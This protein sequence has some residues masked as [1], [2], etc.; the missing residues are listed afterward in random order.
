MFLNVRGGSWFVEEP[1]EALSEQFG[2][3]LDDAWGAPLLLLEIGAGFNTPGV[4]RWPM[5]QVAQG[6]PDAH[7][8]RVNPDHPQVPHE[9]SGRATSVRAGGLAFV[10]ALHARRELPAE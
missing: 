5:E 1:Y 9:L 10:E 8:L 7:L 6:H 2:D 4:I 3:W